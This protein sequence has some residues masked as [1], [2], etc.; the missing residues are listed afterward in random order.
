MTSS[1][2]NDGPELNPASLASSA[3]ACAPAVAEVG[4]CGADAGDAR[5]QALGYPRALKAQRVAEC[6]A[7]VG[8][9]FSP[10]CGSHP[11]PPSVPLHRDPKE[12]MRA[13][14]RNAATY[15][16]EAG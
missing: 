10:E 13:T 11:R 4:G 7:A 9:T 14:Q 15:E 8:R 12:G 3:Y 2:D 6:R 5:D 1:Y 16:T